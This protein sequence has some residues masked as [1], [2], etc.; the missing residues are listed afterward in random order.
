VRSAAAGLPIGVT[1][2]TSEVRRLS[3]EALAK[4]ILRLNQLATSRARNL[5]REKVEKEQPGKY[6]KRELD[7]LGLPT[8]EQLA[9][10]EAILNMDEDEMPETWLRKV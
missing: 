5:V 2:E 3:P 9:R 4:E 1:I 8:K 6:S 10:E 7:D